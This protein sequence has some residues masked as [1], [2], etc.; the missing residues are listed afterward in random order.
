VS[1]QLPVR[2]GFFAYTPTNYMRQVENSQVEVFAVLCYAFSETDPF[3]NNPGLNK[4]IFDL[5]KSKTPS[6]CI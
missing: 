6:K 5:G 4:K 1:L 3:H 2:V